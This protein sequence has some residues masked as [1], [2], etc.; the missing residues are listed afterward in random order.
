[1]LA[2]LAFDPTNVNKHSLAYMILSHLQPKNSKLNRLLAPLQ[3][4]RF[5]VDPKVHLELNNQKNTGTWIPLVPRLKDL[6]RSHVIIPMWKSLQS[7]FKDI[8]HDHNLQMFHILCL[9]QTKVHQSSIDIDK[10]KNITKFHTSQ[11]MIVMD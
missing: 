1:L 5:Y 7:Q 8:Q 2:D 6:Q 10:Y 11:L 3:H 9:M 4:E